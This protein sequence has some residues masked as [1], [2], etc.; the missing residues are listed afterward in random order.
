MRAVTSWIDTNIN[1]LCPPLS[2][3][4]H[5]R[6]PM[7]R[8]WCIFFHRILHAH[9]DHTYT[10]D[11]AKWLTCHPQACSWIIS[12]RAPSKVCEADI[13]N[14]ASSI[15]KEAEAQKGYYIQGEDG[16]AWILPQVPDS[17]D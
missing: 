7:R 13:I 1:R 10:H 9:G 5:P 3:P 4:T 17:R 2:S 15:I 12:V 16:D 14:P 6:S 11:I 8:V